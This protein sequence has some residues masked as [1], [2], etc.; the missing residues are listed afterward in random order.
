MK[1]GLLDSLV[2]C[3]HTTSYISIVKCISN[4]YFNIHWS[5][6]DALNIV[7]VSCALYQFYV[8]RYTPIIIFSLNRSYTG[9]S[10]AIVSFNDD[11]DF[12]RSPLSVYSFSAQVHAQN[13]MKIPIAFTSK[14][15][16]M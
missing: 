14:F 2:R 10:P 12:V 5:G 16:I 13:K 3:S 1:F 7:R 8:L 4:I 15:V 6:F 9:N 11:D